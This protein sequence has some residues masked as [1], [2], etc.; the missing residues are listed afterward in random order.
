MSEFAGFPSVGK[1]TAV[2]NLFFERVLPQM[3]STDELLAFLWVS[4]LVQEQKGEARCVSRDEVW[5]HQA[6]RASFEALG[7]G[8]KGLASGLEACAN[9]GVLLASHVRGA[10]HD[11][12]VFFLNNPQSRRAIAR[13]RSGQLQIRPGTTV[14]HW[15]PQDRPDIFRLYEEHVGTVTPLVAEKLVAAQDEYPFELIEDAFREAAERNVRNW[16]YIERILESRAWEG[17]GHETAS[18]HTFE[19]QKRRYLGG[20]FGHLARYR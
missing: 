18:R 11:E 7:T 16:R 17:S 4:R 8:R 19:E 20:D 6:A 5:A 1:G 15:Q 2:P 14:G 9:A 10:Q 13:A 12:V 3:Q